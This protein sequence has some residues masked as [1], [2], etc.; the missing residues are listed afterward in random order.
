[1]RPAA[2]C[3]D[4]SCGLDVP[5]GIYVS[6]ILKL[7]KYWPRMIPD[8]YGMIRAF[9]FCTIPGLMAGDS[10]LLFLKLFFQFH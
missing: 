8:K 5:A 7:R 6:H 1:M 4:L 10:L 9:L 2:D 3:P